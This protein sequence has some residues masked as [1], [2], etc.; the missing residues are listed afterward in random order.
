MSLSH[1][2]SEACR[3]LQ[4]SLLSSNSCDKYQD[5]DIFITAALLRTPF[6][7]LFTN[8]YIML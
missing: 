1:V 3:W 4:V 2:D 6:N 5:D 8:Q 7:L